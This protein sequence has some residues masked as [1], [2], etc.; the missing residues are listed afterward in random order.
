MPA[1]VGLKA[2]RHRPAAGATSCSCV[3]LRY[4]MARVK[5]LRTRKI[6]TISSPRRGVNLWPRWAIGLWE[7]HALET[8][9]RGNCLLESLREHVLRC[10]CMP[11]LH[12]YRSVRNQVPGFSMPPISVTN[13]R[14]GSTMSIDKKSG[15]QFRPPGSSRSPQKAQISLWEGIPATI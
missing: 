6:S 9:I 15:S 1:P 4:F 11:R 13:L 7:F 5:S 10:L 2:L 3:I 8:E 14:P 12:F